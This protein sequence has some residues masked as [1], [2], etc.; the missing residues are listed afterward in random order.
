M[1]RPFGE[2]L[3]D[4]VARQLK[5]STLKTYWGAPEEA[6]LRLF[7]D[8]HRK[9]VRPRL[10]RFYLY[11]RS[12]E[13]AI[14]LE[15]WMK[16]ISD[17]ERAIANLKRLNYLRSVSPTD[18]VPRAARRART[19]RSPLARQRATCPYFATRLQKRGFELLE[20]L[21]ER[22]ATFNSISNSIV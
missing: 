5:E 12:C 18:P 2:R 13:D 1:K 21:D 17:L 20:L 14:R 4:F 9:T 10:P 19:Q 6:M 15:T 7:Y 8:V 22:T 3:S 11:A 16:R